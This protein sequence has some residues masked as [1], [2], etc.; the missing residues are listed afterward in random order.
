[1]KIY[2]ANKEQ[3]EDFII[4]LVYLLI[5][6]LL[7]L[8]FL[9]IANTLCCNVAQMHIMITLNNLRELCVTAAAVATPSCD[10]T[11]TNQ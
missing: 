8:L 9:I 7:L 3:K 11:L 10:N 2:E 1:M 5:F 4:Y 6:I